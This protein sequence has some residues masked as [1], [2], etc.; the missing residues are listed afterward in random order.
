MEKYSDTGDMFKKIGTRE[1]IK[2]A[3]T[4]NLDGKIDTNLIKQQKQKKH[5]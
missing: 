1:H 3:P 5:D 4:V 2:I